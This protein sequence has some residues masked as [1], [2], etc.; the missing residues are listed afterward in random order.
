HRRGRVR[1][2]RGDDSA[3]SR[4]RGVAAGVLSPS[5]RFSALALLAIVAPAAVVAV[6]GYVSI[7]QWE[8]S[9]ELLYREQARDMAA[10]AAEK[11]EMTLRRAE[12][13]FLD[14]LQAALRS[15]APPE[16]AVDQLMADSPLIRRLYL[17]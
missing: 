12:D 16:R 2:D 13:V 3:A 10:M 4:R 9:S 5:A 15:G 11:V 1:R 7:R 6:L 17:V 14:R 8:A